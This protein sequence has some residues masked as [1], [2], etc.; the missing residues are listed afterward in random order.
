V[1]GRMRE[2]AKRRR[3]LPCFRL[4]GVIDVERESGIGEAR[5]A[6]IGSHVDPIDERHAD[7]HGRAGAGQG[8]GPAREGGRN[9]RQPTT[10]SRL[11]SWRI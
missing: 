4:G 10:R 2:H 1:A 8:E 6:R 3:R 9:V 7:L 11:P 5:D